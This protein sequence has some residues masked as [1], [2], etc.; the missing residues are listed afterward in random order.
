MP[1]PDLWKGFFCVCLFRPI[2]LKTSCQSQTWSILL[3]D[4]M[5]SS[6]LERAVGWISSVGCTQKGC[7]LLHLLSRSSPKSTIE[8]ST[9]RRKFKTP[10][11]Y[12][13][14]QSTKTTTEFKMLRR[15]VTTLRRYTR[16][17]STRSTTECGFLLAGRT[18]GVSEGVA[19]APY[20]A[21][22]HEGQG[23]QQPDDWREGDSNSPWIIKIEF[24]HLQRIPKRQSVFVCRQVCLCQ[25]NA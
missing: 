13:W 6:I 11:G 9:P 12:T 18:F 7:Q 24:R 21:T 16:R 8:C 23:R 10:R 19:P 15:K 4:L 1:F 25:L 17:R 14:G 5:A 22:R 3:S 2:F 20:S